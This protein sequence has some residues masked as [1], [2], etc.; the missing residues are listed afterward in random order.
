MIDA[1]AELA[2]RHGGRFGGELEKLTA[3]RKVG[4]LV[5]GAGLDA[6]RHGSVG[7]IA[8]GAERARLVLK[9]DLASDFL[10]ICLMLHTD[11]YRRGQG[12]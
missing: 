1:L 9:V 12:A 8:A 3:R 4:F 2:D 6:P 5:G 7:A 11:I 10:S